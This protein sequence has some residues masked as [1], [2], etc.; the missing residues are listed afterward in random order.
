M[1][2]G[3]NLLRKWPDRRQ[4]IT[5]WDLTWLERYRPGASDCRRA[6]QLLRA[7]VPG[8]GVASEA[9]IGG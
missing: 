9:G 2:S 7:A 8:R 3:T 4:A 1:D 5:M 6:E